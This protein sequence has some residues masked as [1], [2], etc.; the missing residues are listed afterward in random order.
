MDRTECVLKDKNS[1]KNK[2]DPPYA[3]ISIGELEE[4]FLKDC[5]FKPLIW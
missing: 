4:Q 5:S 1:P 3:I 2:M